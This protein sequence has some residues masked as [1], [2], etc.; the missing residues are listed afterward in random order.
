ML[1]FVCLRHKNF[2]ISKNI[3]IDLSLVYKTRYFC[4]VMKSQEQNPKNPSG[5]CLQVETR[6]H[7]KNPLGFKKFSNFSPS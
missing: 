3:S 7:D 4:A 5:L 2:L 6:D 1:P